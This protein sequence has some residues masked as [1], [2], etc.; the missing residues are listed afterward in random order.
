MFRPHF[1]S[2]LICLNYLGIMVNEP[3]FLIV[4]LLVIGVII[5]KLEIPLKLCNTSLYAGSVYNTV[6]TT[7]V[8][9]LQKLSSSKLL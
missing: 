7:I 9:R 2:N 3:T 4:V 6:I 1:S 8:K 5:S